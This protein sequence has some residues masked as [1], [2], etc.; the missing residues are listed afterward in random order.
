MNNQ[1]SE[2]VDCLTRRWTDIV[3]VIESGDRRYIPVDHAPLL[4]MLHGMIG[5]NFGGNTTGATAAST[6]NILNLAAFTLYENIDGTAR[7]WWRELSKSRPSEN[8]LDLV[9]ELA[10]LLV[11]Q[12]ASG[13][14]DD[15]TFVRISGQFPEWRRQIWE[16]FD[17]PVVKELVGACPHCDERWVYAPDG[18]KSSALIVYY[19]RSEM[20]EAKC[21]RCGEVWVG[22]KQLLT[23]GFHLGATVDHEALRE[24]GVEGAA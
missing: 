16:M 1:M 11:A 21:Q 3:T 6:S 24:M 12:R 23:L 4:D 8:L 2:A 14:V 13:Q 20:P 10:G 5:S 9:R 19:V 15:V 22:A 17:P 7:A 18:G